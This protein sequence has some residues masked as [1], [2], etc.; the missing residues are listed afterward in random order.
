MPDIT[1]TAA[2][3]AAI[4]TIRH[5][6]GFTVSDLDSLCQ[7]TDLDP[8]LRDMLTTMARGLSKVCAALTPTNL[9]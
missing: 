6:I 9:H 4:A 7:D 8:T 5:Q 3:H 2:Q 1:I